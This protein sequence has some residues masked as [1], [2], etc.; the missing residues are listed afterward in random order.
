MEQLMSDEDLVRLAQGLDAGAP[1]E[2][3]K[4]TL[5]TLRRV[6]EEGFLIGHM[7]AQ[8]EKDIN[9]ADE[10]D[11]IAEENARNAR[12]RREREDYEYRLRKEQEYY[13]RTGRRPRDNYVTMGTYSGSVQQI[14]YTNN[15]NPF[16]IRP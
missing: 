7:S 8:E 1:V 12:E 14:V 13:E 5:V 10:D 16:S 6:L 4:K 2:V 15:T 11:T 3:D 9:K